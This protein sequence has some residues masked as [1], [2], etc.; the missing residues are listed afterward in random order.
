M[1]I[2]IKAFAVAQ[3]GDQLLQRDI[4]QLDDLAAEALLTH[5][6]NAIAL[7]LKQK[8]KTTATGER[9]LETDDFE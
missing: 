8:Q 4:V 3:W 1:L 7:R 9:S 2:F 5:R 6:R